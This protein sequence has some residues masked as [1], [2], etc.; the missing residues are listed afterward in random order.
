MGPA[1]EDS[2]S[3]LPLARSVSC[4]RRRARPAS[5]HATT[6]IAIQRLS[7]L[8]RDSQRPS[9]P[10]RGCGRRTAPLTT[11][12]EQGEV[13]PP[14]PNPS[15]P[16]RGRGASISSIRERI[17]QHRRSNRSA[18]AARL[19]GRTSLLLRQCDDYSPTR[20]LCRPRPRSGASLQW[21]GQP[22]AGGASTHS[23]AARLQDLKERST[24]APC[25]SRLLQAEARPR[26]SVE[27]AWGLY[28]MTCRPGCLAGC[29][30]RRP[31]GPMGVL[32]VVYMRL[33]HEPSGK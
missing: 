19:K 2:A 30:S 13:R 33:R 21:P 32:G 1:T 22:P 24:D 16:K 6:R 15:P 14:H 23:P 4:K 18:V 5:D 7:W 29:G 20:L 31:A 10:K 3:Y 25:D 12:R 8:S 11:M 27:T 26:H 17:S 28:S 9:L